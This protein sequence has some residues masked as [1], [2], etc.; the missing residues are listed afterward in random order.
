MRLVG[1]G[2]REGGGIFQTIKMC[3]LWRGYILS[4]SF[5]QVTL[6]LKDIILP[7]SL[8]KKRDFSP[9]TWRGCIPSTDMQTYQ[10]LNVNGL[11]VFAVGLTVFCW[12]AGWQDTSCSL[13]IIPL[14]H[15]HVGRISFWGSLQYCQ[16]PAVAIE[17]YYARSEILFIETL[18]WF[19]FNPLR[20]LE[21]QVTPTIKCF[22]ENIAQQYLGICP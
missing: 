5:L 8:W 10:I 6:H 18:I 2:E 14:N 12:K 13:W 17:R 3:N 19:L 9:I 22:H 21:S 11:A 20:A 16:T 7:L 4:L 1:F 15:S